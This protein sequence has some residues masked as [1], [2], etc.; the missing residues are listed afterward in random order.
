MLK[1]KAGPRSR[2]D[3]QLGRLGSLDSQAAADVLGLRSYP[4]MDHE[5]WL[6]HVRA[7]EV[8]NGKVASTN[9]RRYFSPAE[10]DILGHEYRP[11][12]DLGQLNYI[13]PGDEPYDVA[14]RAAYRIALDMVKASDKG[15]QAVA[16]AYLIS[17][18]LTARERA[19]R[20][21]KSQ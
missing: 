4:P 21:A 1:R 2:K 15:K 10:Q 6:S 5:E 11:N 13:V 8:Y 7:G 20:D 19:S 14:E 17:Y 16:R 18:I 12:E 9:M 3:S